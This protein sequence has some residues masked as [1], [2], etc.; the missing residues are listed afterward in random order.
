MV[1]IMFELVSYRKPIAALIILPIMLCLCAQARADDGF[2]AKREHLIRVIEADVR[3]TSAYLKR[4]ELD[5]RVLDSM[6]RVPRHEFVPEHLL[7]QAYRN[8]PLPIGH[9]QTISQPYIVA[10]MTDLLEPRPGHRLL[11]IGTGSGYQAA[12]LAA[13]DTRVFSIEIIEPLGLQARQRLARLD[14]AVETRIGDGYYGWPEEAPFDGIIVTAAASHIPPPLVKQ[15]RVGGKTII[16][17]GSRFATQ[18]LILITR[19]SEDEVVTRQLLPVR[20]V[21]LTG[22]H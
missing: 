11:E 13:L 4:S 20:F 10:I 19:I 12:V 6:R 22:K 7:G 1:L 3:D 18:E 15:L 9:G 8:R 2:R 14:Y 5:A 21:P 17:V 16:P